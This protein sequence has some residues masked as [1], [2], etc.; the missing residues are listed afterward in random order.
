[1]QQTFDLR[2][3]CYH[4][5]LNLWRDLWKMHPKRRPLPT[6]FDLTHDEALQV[7]QEFLEANGLVE[8]EKA[9]HALAQRRP[10]TDTHE[11]EGPSSG[12]EPD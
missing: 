9:L 1:M 11:E 2:K 7:E 6:A 8:D 5:V 3:A 4:Q 10:T 12:A